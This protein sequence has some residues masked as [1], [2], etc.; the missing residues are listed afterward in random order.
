MSSIVYF[1][2]NFN[3]YYNRIIK[4]YDSVSD[5]INEIGEENYAIRGEGTGIVQGNKGPVNFN[6]NDG[7]NAVMTYNYDQN[8]D[9][10][11]NYILVCDL[12]H[13]IKSRWFVMEA[14]RTRQ[15]QYKL[16]LHR[17]VIADDYEHI[18][19]SPVYFERAMLSKDNP[20]LFKNESNLYNQIKQD[21]T[22][23][24]DKSKCA[25][26]VGY[27]SKPKKE[28]S[29]ETVSD[30]YNLDFDIYYNG[31]IESYLGDYWNGAKSVYN[32]SDF[33]ISFT[34]AGQNI[35]T[36][37]NIYTSSGGEFTTSMDLFGGSKCYYKEYTTE[38][39]TRQNLYANMKNVD[40]DT[41]IYNFI[42]A[43]YRKKLLRDISDDLAKDGKTIK[44]VYKD[45]SGNEVTEYYKLSVEVYTSF[46]E[47]LMDTIDFQNEDTSKYTSEELGAYNDLKS[48]YTTIANNSFNLASGDNLY[49]YLKN[50]SII[51]NIDIHA[52]EVSVSNYNVNIDGNR[53][54]LV[55]QPYSMFCI[56]YPTN[57]EIYVQPYSGDSFKVDKEASMI[58]TSTIATQLGE[59][60]YDIQ[61]LP[62]CPIQGII[63]T[64]GDNIV[65]DVLN[66][67]KVNEGEGIYDYIKINDTYKTKCSILIWCTQSTFTFNIATSLT[68][69]TD[70][71]EFKVQDETE[72]YR[73]NS[74]NYNGTYEFKATRNNGVEY[75]N[76]DCTYKPY[77]PYI[78]INPNFKYMYGNDYNDV[79][80]LICSGNFSLTQTT[81]QWKNYIVNNKTYQSVFD[82]QIT[83]MD[84][85][86]N[87]QNTQSAWN[88]AA[89]GISA[90]VSGAKLG[91]TAAVAGGALST[92]AGI[93][94]LEFQKDL[95]RESK[96]YATD[97]F[98][99]NN[100]AIQ[101]RPDTLNKIDSFNDNNKIY[102]ILER[103][104]CTDNEKEQLRN[105]LKYNSMSVN[106]ISTISNL[107]QTDITF[108][109]GKLIKYIS[110]KCGD[111]NYTTAIA[112]ELNK[113]VFI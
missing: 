93:A 80:G 56:P 57:N 1:L 17:D 73:L 7:V 92:V 95:Q 63:N 52:T 105:Q 94:D 112:E 53:R 43:H 108:M 16:S 54:S 87:I 41:R 81:D 3:N 75:F 62:Y 24:Q 18:T 26:L 88:I 79:N 101:A 21:E 68:T 9:W 84:V 85:N 66:Y 23:L 82:R 6:I 19:T 45:D 49:F 76:V 97:I 111:Y 42:K 51:Q 34:A 58:M 69:K 35:S 32:R 11:P 22:L 65:I 99:L 78:H 110:D 39:M 28:E 91:T 70:N 90:A 27:I 104:D 2:N 31:K 50:N 46:T 64:T 74:P 15:G 37:K 38:A 4:K 89:G 100:Q 86:Y 36:I 59:K 47:E 60:C 20:L 5:Y 96:S 83:N 72:F 13:T 102:P 33:T 40:I 48:A 71:I 109:K 61:L 55:D 77:T 107:Q 30:N 67:L 29:S 12:E 98:N 44:C 113:G 10:Q 8:Q 25:W 106:L 103:Y 14:K